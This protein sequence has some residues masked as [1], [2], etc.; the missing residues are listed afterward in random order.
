[1]KNSGG[2]KKKKALG[3]KIF[4]LILVAVLM[5]IAFAIGGNNSI[6]TNL[7]KRLADNEE[8]EGKDR[9]SNNDGTY[10]LSLSVTG[11]ADTKPVI[12]TKAN[13]LVIYD[14]SGSMSQQSYKYTL[15]TS[16]SGTQ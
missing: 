4:G 9:I 8:I 6:L 14:V 13:V 3:S 5:V 2:N 11:D 1:M 12:T 15:T 16:N 7:Q 10:K